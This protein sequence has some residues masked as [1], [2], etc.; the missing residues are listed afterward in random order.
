M[1]SMQACMRIYCDLS[2]VWRIVNE[3]IYKSRNITSVHVQCIYCEGIGVND[4]SA[5]IDRDA[6]FSKLCD[7]YNNDK[8]IAKH[9]M[10]TIMS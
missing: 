3:M 4:V 8:N 5:D 1:I 7:Q 2:I 10:H 6:S 9:T